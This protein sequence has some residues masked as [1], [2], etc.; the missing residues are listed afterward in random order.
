M[1]LAW[2]RGAP[3]DDVLRRRVLEEVRVIAWTLSEMQAMLHEA[4]QRTGLSHAYLAPRL[5][6]RLPIF[7]VGLRY[8]LVLMNLDEPRVG[9]FDEDGKRIAD[10][11]LL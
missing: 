7:D 1:E 10:V 2:R 8:R 6:L 11:R 9:L 4:H 5:E 3:E